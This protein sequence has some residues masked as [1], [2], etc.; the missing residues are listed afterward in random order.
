MY[1]NVRESSDQCHTH[2]N[3]SFIKSKK[4]CIHLSDV[5]SALITS[6]E[7]PIHYIS[8]LYGRSAYLDLPKTAFGK[9]LSSRLVLHFCFRDFR[10][11][12]TKNDLHVGWA[13]HVWIDTS[14]GT[15]CAAALLWSPI[16]LDAGNVKVPIKALILGWGGV[17]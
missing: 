2:I 8:C 15:T 9:L 3:K 5:S 7:T 1:Y 10:R 13:A 6:S 14:M 17:C 11:F 12:L 4:R 16:A